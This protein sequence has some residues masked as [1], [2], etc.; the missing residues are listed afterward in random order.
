LINV[1]RAHPQA[2][3]YPLSV[4]SK[5]DAPARVTAANYILDK[6]R[7]HSDSLVEAALLV[8]HELIRVA[9]P[10]QELWKEGIEEAWQLYSIEKN[11]E[12]MTEKLHSLNQLIAVVRQILI[13]L[14]DTGAGL[15][16]WLVACGHNTGRA[17]ASR[18]DVHAHV[19]AR[20]G[21]GV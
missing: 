5:S 14:R 9:I 12:G 8:S 20:P 7:E 18:D 19:R 3:V 11:V 13:T 16:L 21:R 2:L 6:M 17:D 1:G 15:T 4:A 10:W